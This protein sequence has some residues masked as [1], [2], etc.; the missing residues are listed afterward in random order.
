MTDRSGAGSHICGIESASHSALYDGYV[1][2]FSFKIFK[3]DSSE[4]FKFG[5]MICHLATETGD[6]GNNFGKLMFFNRKAIQTDS[7][8]EKFKIGRSKKPCPIS[9]ASQDRFQHGAKGAFPVCSG[10]MWARKSLSGFPRSAKSS[11]I[12]E[13]PD[14]CR[15]IPRNV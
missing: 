10:N 11:V 5:R 3:S 4:Q 2:F 6:I 14:G 1:Y 15:A 12:L 7:L 13:S 8:F 9:G